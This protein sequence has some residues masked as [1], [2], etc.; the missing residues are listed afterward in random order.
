MKLWET[1]DL[2]SLLIGLLS[3][4][5][6]AFLLRLQ[7]LK[8]LSIDVKKI[9][10]NLGVEGFEERSS[11]FNV[12]NVGRD[13]AGRD[14]NKDHR[15]YKNTNDLYNVIQSLKD[16]N[17]P[18]IQRNQRIQA[19]D[20]SASFQ[21][22]LKEIHQN[23]GD[24]TKSWIDACLENPSIKRQ[25]NSKI[26]EISNDGWTVRRLGLDNTADGINVIFETD[27]PFENSK[28]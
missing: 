17:T 23:G 2:M 1:F 11:G 15:K 21:N 16:D 20:K 10:F 24:W 25:I 26:S 8:K 7:S 12:G 14:M 5:V 27:R 22:Q 6:S 9:G 28:A 13:F 19:S 18:K 4:A 3:G